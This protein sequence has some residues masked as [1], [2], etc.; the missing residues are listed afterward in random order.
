MP[1]RDQV[2]IT[3]Q[4]SDS[5]AIEAISRAMSEAG[6]SQSRLARRLGTTQ[7]SV[8]R[9]LAGKTPIS[10]PELLLIADEL[11]VPASALLGDSAEVTS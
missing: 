7:Q 10:V 3:C 9:R 1:S 6:V 2:V 4:S 11:G 8:S 5:G